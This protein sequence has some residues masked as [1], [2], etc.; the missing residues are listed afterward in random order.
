MKI[1]IAQTKALKGNVQK[2]IR[3]H[4]LWIEYAAE[5][6]ADLIIF[7]ELSLTGYEPQLAKGLAVKLEDKIF[8]L[9]Q[10][11]SIKLNITI[12]VGMPII[13]KNGINISL[14]I[15]QPNTQSIAYSKQRLHTDELPYFTCGT[16]QLFLTIKGQKIAF[17][18]CYET[19]QTEHFLFANQNETDIYIA[20]V[21]KSKDGIEKAYSHF[22]KMANQFKTP[23][24]MSNS[25]GYCD[26][27]MGAGN[28]AVW[29]KNGNLLRQ[30]DDENQGILVY[31][32]QLET[33]KIHQLKIEKGRLSDL[34]PI[35]KI[36]LNAKH[37]LEKKGIYQW[38]DQYPTKSIIESDLQKGVLY[39]LKYG[40]KIIGAINLSEEQE[41]EYQTVKW[42]FNHSKALVIHRLVINPKHQ[43]LGYA[44]KSMAFAENFARKMGYS[45]IR[46]DAYSYNKRVIDFYQKRNY[47]IRGDV[48]FPGRK[49]VFHCME[50]EIVNS[51]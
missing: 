37:E 41:K 1:C 40:N 6:N 7:P 48:N 31:D 21:A 51:L 36:Y 18:I 23:I 27:F 30:L 20:S 39:M 44:Q 50:K 15:F 22:P 46:L 49:Y 32:T 5:L 14:L 38:T 34:E 11:Y 10:E 26:N 35:F 25:V 4:L 29:D 47:V 43:G 16:S 13:A 2:N 19:L 24:L 17:G 42:R 28:S 45:S 12:G 33:T 8:N 9:F 3:N